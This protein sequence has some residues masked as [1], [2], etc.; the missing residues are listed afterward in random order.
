M[1]TQMRDFKLFALLLFLPQ[2]LQ[3]RKHFYHLHQYLG[4]LDKLNLMSQ[5]RVEKD[6]AR[7]AS[8]TTPVI[9]ASVESTLEHT[10]KDQ[11]K[12]KRP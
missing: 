1:A 9:L 12:F 10:V 11:I 5:V 4:E 6:M 7:M 8:S 3:Q 2:R